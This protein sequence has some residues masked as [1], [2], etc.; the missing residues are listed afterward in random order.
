MILDV[1]VKLNPE[2]SW[3][4]QHSTRRRLFTNK[5]DLNL[6]KKL[7]KC[8]IWSIALYGGETWTLWKVGQK[9]LESFEM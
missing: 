8:Y 7:M 4:R 6:R 5:L 3:Q 1:H 9:Y 2:L